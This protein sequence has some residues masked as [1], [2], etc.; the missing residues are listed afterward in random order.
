VHFVLKGSQ[1]PS[2]ASGVTG[3]EGDAVRPDAFEGSLVVTGAGLSGTVK[4]VSVG[5]VVYA[6]LPLIPGYHRIDPKSYGFGD[7][8]EFIDAATGLSSLLVTPTQATYDG[9]TRTDG[10]VLDRVKAQLPGPP[11]ARLLGSAD[12]TTAVAAEIGIE[13]ASHQIRS[14]VLTG[15]F[16]SAKQPSTF[17]LTLSK[18]GESVAVR[19]PG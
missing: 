10:V 16:F 19:A 1:V 4:V 13:R 15:P 11:V 6:K 17:T 8:G 18:Y 5:H 3:G 7:P 14:V 9:Q 2:G 12:S